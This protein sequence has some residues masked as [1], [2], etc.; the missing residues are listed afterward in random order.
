MTKAAGTFGAQPLHCCGDLR[1]VHR[2]QN[3]AALAGFARRFR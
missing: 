2:A 3:G 1:D